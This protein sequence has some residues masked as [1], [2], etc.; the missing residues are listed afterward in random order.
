MAKWIDVV[1]FF[2]SDEYD[3]IFW[4]LQEMHR[5]GVNV[6]PEPR[7]IL[8][9]YKLTPFEDVKV[10]ILGQDPYPNKEHAMGLAFSVKPE[11]TMLPA[12]LKNIFKELEDNVGVKRTNGCLKD[13]A[14]Q[15]VLLLNTSLTVE[16]GKPNSH[17]SLGWDKLI[18]QTIVAVNDKLEHV[19]FVLW[20]NNA[21]RKQMYIDDNKH[22]ILVSAH[23]SP[24]SAHRGFFGSR[25][26]S[27]INTILTS[28]GNQPIVW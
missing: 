28:Y 20:G 5:R 3:A 14:E 24:L 11:V 2:L 8:N 17:A 15:G 27:M 23:P 9:A 18:K 26:F 1:P 12:S 19:V 22:H 25:P 10:V 4:K 7:N 16:E 6:L 13:W 21:Q